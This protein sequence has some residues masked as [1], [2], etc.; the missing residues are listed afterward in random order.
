[1]YGTVARMKLKPGGIEALKRMSEGQEP[2]PGAVAF[3]AYQMDADPNEI[4]MVAIF[5]SKQSYLA[6]A[7]SPEQNAQ[8]QKWA[9]WFEAEPEW[10]DGEI[11]YAEHVGG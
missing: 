6:N 3:Y 2:A 4:Y 5:E 1:M 9:E 11:I 7:Q 10:H 8:Y